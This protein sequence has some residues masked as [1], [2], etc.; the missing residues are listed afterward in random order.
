MNLTARV[1]PNQWFLIS[2]LEL[3]AYMCCMMQL[4]VCVCSPQSNICSSP[5]TVASACCGG[6]SVFSEQIPVINSNLLKPNVNTSITDSAVPVAMGLLHPTCGG[7]ALAGCFGGQLLSGGF[8]S[9]GLTGCLLGT[10]HGA[11]WSPDKKPTITDLISSS[12]M[13]KKTFI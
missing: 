12:R 4:E 7:R 13:V 6:F 3:L 11:K 2:H 9:S 1:D 8:S 10:S 5:W